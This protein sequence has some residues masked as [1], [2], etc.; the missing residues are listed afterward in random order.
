MTSMDIK[1]M[2]NGTMIILNQAFGNRV[3]LLNL[4][5]GIVLFLMGHLF[6]IEYIRSNH[7]DHYSVIFFVIVPILLYI[8]SFR[9]I[10][11]AILSEKLFIGSREFR[12][13]RKKMFGSKSISFETRKIVNLRYFENKFQETQRKSGSL[14][15][16][17]FFKLNDPLI[18][19]LD[20]DNR[21]FFDYENQTVSFGSGIVS[22][23]FDEIKS[24]F[25]HARTGITHSFPL[26]P[27]TH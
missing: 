26:F 4:F 14:T 3:K 1:P 23:E 15:K 16:L 8:I 22:F 13:I 6:L 12:I 10:N 27:G 18:D 24:V 17:T 20:S 5:Y 21:I 9:F 25:D 7:N 2:G 11:K 19:Q